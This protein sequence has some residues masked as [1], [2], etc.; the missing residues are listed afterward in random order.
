[1]RIRISMKSLSVII[2]S[3]IIAVTTSAPGQKKYTGPPMFLNVNAIKLDMK[4]INGEGQFTT[5][6]S[7]ML[8]DGNVKSEIFQYPQD[9]W[10]SRLLYQ[11]F[12]PIAPDDS[13]FIDNFGNRK[14][15]PTP[16]VSIGIN[17]FSQEIRRYRPPY[18][19]VDGIT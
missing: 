3:G 14:I 15:I 8:T 11:I 5:Q 4:K 6:Y 1:M 7:W 19:T 12:N 18:V 16:F 10:H 9:E 13:G 17:D 2:L